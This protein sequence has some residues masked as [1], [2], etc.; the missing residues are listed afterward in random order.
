MPPILSIKDLTRS[1]RMGKTV[2]VGALHGVSFSVQAGEMIA[3]LG[4]S[5]SGKSTLL[6]LI[7]GLDTPS[8]G[9]IVCEGKDLALMNQRQLADHRRETVGMVFQSFNLVQWMS[10][11]DNVA[12]ALQYKGFSKVQARDRARHVLDGVG[13]GP[14]SSHRPSELSGGEQQRVAMARA[15]ANQPK[16]LLADEPTGNLD[17]NTSQELMELI[18]A[19][20]REQ[21]LT[22]LIITHDEDIARQYTQRWIRLADGEIVKD[23]ILADEP[24]AGAGGAA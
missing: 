17:T 4:K 11:L 9:S 22:V 7:A 16:I 21:G 18:R 12:L 10:A 1:Y 23:L 13:L 2:Q 8:S 3:I 6:N 20:N 19:K 24:A 5:G 14:R 15:M